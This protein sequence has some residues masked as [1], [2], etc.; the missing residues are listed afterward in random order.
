MVSIGLVNPKS[1]ANVA[2]IVRAAGCYGASSIFYTG[3]RFRYAKEFNADTKSFHRV[4]PTVGVENIFDYVPQGARKVAVELVVG[5]I[6][7]PEYQHP[8]NAFYLLGPEDGSLD[9]NTLAQ[10][11][12]VVYIPTRSCMNLSATANVLLYD[13]MCK[14]GYDRGQS[15]I[16]RS[17]DN[18][19][20]SRV[21]I[22]Q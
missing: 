12:D 3:Q 19:N 18:N 2:G 21:V 17:R 11:D 15:L 22:S 10:C 16:E 9:E 8:G 1:A 4:I 13:R 7:L 5:A 6:P 20:N 14:Q